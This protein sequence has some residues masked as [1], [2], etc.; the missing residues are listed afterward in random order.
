MDGKPEWGKLSLPIQPE[1][2]EIMETASK[3]ELYK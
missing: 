3:T 1:P 2:L